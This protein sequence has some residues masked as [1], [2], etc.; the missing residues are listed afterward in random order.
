MPEKDAPFR[1][2][3]IALS[4]GLLLPSQPAGKLVPISIP[5]VLLGDNNS[6]VSGNPVPS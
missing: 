2:I 6:I 4:M 3:L 1:F 5:E